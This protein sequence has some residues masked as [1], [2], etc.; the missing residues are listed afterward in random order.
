MMALAALLLVAA[1]IFSIMNRGFLL[2]TLAKIKDTK[3]KIIVANKELDAREV[4]RK[5]FEEDESEA[6]DLRNIAK[7]AMEES[8]EKLAI[9]T[10]KVNQKID[11]IKKIDKK[12]AELDVL[13]KLIFP[14]GIVETPDEIRSRLDGDKDVL[15][16]RK[17]RQSE[18]ASSIA[19][20]QAE[21]AR[22]QSRVDSEEDKQFERRK[23]ILLGGLEATIIGANDQWGFLIVNAGKELGVSPD[24]KLLVKRAGRQIATL[25]ITTL[26]DKVSV[27]EV[28]KDSVLDRDT[29]VQPGDKVIFQD[30]FRNG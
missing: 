7:A 13:V 10:R 29:R 3:A 11:N 9:E 21:Q 8:Q 12:Q 4:E 28:I 16:S 18:L 2:D 14:N 19:K 5:G 23:K 26:R 17:E 6:K 30:P 24:S 25:R 1:I 27:C 20:L 15:A 22:Q